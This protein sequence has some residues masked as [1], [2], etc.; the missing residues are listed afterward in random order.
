MRAM[1]T[2]LCIFFVALVGL[3]ACAAH[4]SGF[5][6]STFDHP[7]YHY[8]IP[9]AAGAG[10]GII[11]DAWL[12]ENY[13]LA[14]GVPKKPKVGSDYEFVREYDFEDDGVIDARKK[15]LY[16]DIRLVHRKRDAVIFVRTVPLTRTESGKDI[17]VFA[18]RYVESAA[19]SGQ[20]LVRFGN[21]GPVGTVG[22]HF[23]SR[24]LSSGACRVAG[25]SAYRMDYEVASVEQLELAREAR[26]TRGRVVMV[27]TPYKAVFPLGPM[28]R[29]QYPVLLIAGFVAEPEDFETLRGDFEHML[30]LL[31][32]KG[33]SG[34]SCTAAE[35]PAAQAEQ[36][37]APPAIAPP[38]P[39]PDPAPTTP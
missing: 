9:P 21:D 28:R 24:T 15:E 26:W 35:V 1:L 2:R 3:A 38:T 30:G 4:P 5:K 19:G 12:L 37:A 32:I 29:V 11:S 8:K 33:K 27:E 36:P 7:K 39:A 25:H 16:Y 17:D 10:A 13:A 6:T 20:V 23:A 22:G 34:S 31:D 14:E 18:K